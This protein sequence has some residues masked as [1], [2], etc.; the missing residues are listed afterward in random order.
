MEKLVLVKG[1]DLTIVFSSLNNV[2]FPEKYNYQQ[3]SLIKHSRNSKTC[4]KAQSKPIY[5]IARQE[6]SLAVD[7]QSVNVLFAIILFHYDFVQAL[8]IAELLQNKVSINE[9]RFMCSALLHC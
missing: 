9:N 2:V 7:S 5:H 3:K 8:A 4:C 1:S 6:K